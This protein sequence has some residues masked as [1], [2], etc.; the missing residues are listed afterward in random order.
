VANQADPNDAAWFPDGAPDAGLAT[1][2]Q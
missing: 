1:W 2:P